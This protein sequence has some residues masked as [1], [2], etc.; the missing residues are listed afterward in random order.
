LGRY[1]KMISST[2]YVRTRAAAGRADAGHMR[3][4]SIVAHV[5]M[6]AG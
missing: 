2:A 4:L 1:P 5:R 6:P 3:P